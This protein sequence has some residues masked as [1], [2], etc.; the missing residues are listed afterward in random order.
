LVVAAKELSTKDRGLLRARETS[1]A[2]VQSGEIEKSLGQKPL[3]VGS[4]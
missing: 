1:S 3:A 4:S 2:S